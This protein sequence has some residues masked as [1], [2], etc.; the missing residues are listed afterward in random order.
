MAMPTP[1]AHLDMMP[2]MSASA[3]NSRFVKERLKVELTGRFSRPVP[4]V[5][6][7]PTV[8]SRLWLNRYLKRAQ[9]QN[10]DINCLLLAYNVAAGLLYLHSNGIIHGDLKGLNVLINTDERA[11]IGDFG[12]SHV[13]ETHT[14]RLFNSTTG[15]K[16]TIC[17]LSPELLKANPPCCT[18]ERSDI[19]AYAGVCYEIFT[20]KQPF[21]KLHDMAVFDAVVI[22]E[23]CPDCPEEARELSDPI[24]GIMVSCW[25]HDQQLRPSVGDVLARIGE[26]KNPKTGAT[27]RTGSTLDLSHTQSSLESP[28]LWLGAQ[29]LLTED[30]HLQPAIFPVLKGC[31]LQP[32]TIIPPCH[33]LWHPEPNASLPN[34]YK[35]DGIQ[36]GDVGVITGEGR[37]DF[38]FNI[39][40]GVDDPINE[41]GVPYDF[42]KPLDL[43]K[44]V[45]VHSLG[46]EQGM[47]LCGPGT[48][49][50]NIFSDDTI[51]PW[52][53]F[54]KEHFG[55]D[56]D[57]TLFLVT[58]VKMASS[59]EIA[60]VQKRA[61]KTKLQY[62]PGEGLKLRSKLLRDF[63]Q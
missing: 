19:Y 24:W 60:V 52:Y 50:W 7:L 2:L 42:D 34:C 51:T 12:L 17:W 62:I 35:K 18:S 10:A 43:W 31:P 22:R 55:D 38:L 46:F 37:F 1:L 45:T 47:L 21:Y 26:L 5:I 3:Q 44:S 49:L 9:K 23:E 28:S 15:A 11:L 14:P 59:W 54:A 33:A 61:N 39:S 57:D 30:R 20:G 32:I 6:V 29:K 4:S 41:Y 40:R 58:G 48:S 27:V 56:F 53:Q 13:A 25:Q 16:G 36:I 63:P 8:R